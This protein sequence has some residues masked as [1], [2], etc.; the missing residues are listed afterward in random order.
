MKSGRQRIYLYTKLYNNIIILINSR[1]GA[2]SAVCMTKHGNVFQ[3]KLL[4]PRPLLRHSDDISIIVLPN[5]TLY[6][7]PTPTCLRR[8]TTVTS[9]SN[10]TAR[11]RRRSPPSFGDVGIGY[12]HDTGVI[13]HFL[14]E[15]RPEGRFI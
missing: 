15:F 1:A 3:S 8:C 11:G 14:F 5:Q 6:S 10:H 2:Y 9:Q 7:R 12:D 4:C 13:I